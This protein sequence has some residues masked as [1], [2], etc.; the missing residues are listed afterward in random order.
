MRE[1]NRFKG[2]EFDPLGKFIHNLTL[3]FFRRMDLSHLNYGEYA[4]IERFNL[5]FNSIEFDGFGLII[6]TR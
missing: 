2:I 1:Q 3:H 6:K 4:T 5:H